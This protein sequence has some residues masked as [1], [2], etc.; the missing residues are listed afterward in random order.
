MC[1]IVGIFNK[2]GVENHTLIQDMMEKIH[3]RGPDNQ[4]SYTNREIS[5]GFQRLT[6]IDV[7]ENGNQPMF[8]ENERYVMVFNGEIYNFQNLREDLLLKGHTFHSQADSEV[9]LHGFEQYGPD[10]LQKLRG[11]F[12]FSIWDKVEKQ[13]FIARDMFGIKP[14]YYTQETTDG[15]F[16]FGSEIK[17]FL[18]HPQFRKSFNDEAL[19]PYLT[20]QYSA[21]EETFFEGVYK[22]PPGHYMIHDG[23]N[24]EIRPYWEPSYSEETTNLNEAIKNIQEAM[25]DSIR[26]HKISDVEVGSFLSGGID[27]SYVT[28]LLKP[29][30][31]FSIGFEDYEGMFNETTLA[32][33]LSQKIEVENHKRLISAD[34][35]FQA[36][37]TIQYHMDEPHA[38]LSSVP[39][40][41]LSE[42]AKEHVTVVLSGEGADEL[43]GGY[44][45]YKISPEQKIYEKVPFTIRKSIASV[46]S[47]LPKNR[48]TSF[49]TSGGEKIEEKFIGHAKVFRPEDAHKVL[50]P[51]YRQNRKPADLLS[52]TYAQVSGA[53]DSTKMQYADLH[54]W[55]PGDILQKADKMSSAHSLE[56]RVPFL[57]A[58]VM[59][60][61][62]SLAPS[63]RAN[64]KD[65]KYALREA[66]K[67]VLPEEWANRKKVGFPVPI[68]DWLRQK[69]YYDLVKTSLTSETA[70]EFFHT[71][72]LVQ[73]LDDHYEGKGNHHRYIWTVYVFLQWYDV[74]FG[75]EVHLQEEETQL[76]Y[77]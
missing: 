45:W 62:S 56:L 71:Q 17:S 10:I 42:L 14:L 16:L 66:A 51:A 41:F 25:D 2:K 26:H 11:M 43:F 38:N 40:F 54:H 58:K 30:K 60:V 29:N 19:Q 61:A 35:F 7:S 12:A 20:F 27:S 46:S 53:N 23:G 77:A 75:G 67:A 6:I 64:G 74:Y 49:L 72:A 21:M 59:E 4:G 13:L 24:Y 34:D 8:S 63:L 5:L 52:K 68:R 28:S 57:D 48:I 76:A 39:L 69:E 65:T 47:K 22:L 1:G 73:Y 33:E 55:L 15:S 36:V 32:E 50:K 18:A 31:T 44:D 9:V 3:H 37:P 70:Q